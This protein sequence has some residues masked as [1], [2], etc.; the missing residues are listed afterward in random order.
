MTKFLEPDPWQTDEPV[1]LIDFAAGS[2]FI[3]TCYH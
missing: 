1:W 3:A 2:L